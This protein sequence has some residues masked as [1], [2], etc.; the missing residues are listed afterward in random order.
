[1]TKKVMQVLGLVEEMKLEETKT[2]RV[3]VYYKRHGK[4]VRR[5]CDDYQYTDRYKE[6]LFGDVIR[7]QKI[8]KC[9]SCKE[10]VDY[11]SLESWCCDFNKGSYLC[12]SCYE[13]EMSEDL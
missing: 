2:I 9:H 5:F 13:E 8:F 4:M 11:F 12:A 10:K 3:P 7:G 6:L 1:M